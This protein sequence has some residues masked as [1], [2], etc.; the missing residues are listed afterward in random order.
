M[1]V[2]VV[3][4]KASLSLA[5]RY[6]KN[7]GNK[8]SIV[9]TILQQVQGIHYFSNNQLDVNIKRVYLHK[10][11]YDEKSVTA[12]RDANV[13][14]LIQAQKI[15]AVQN[16]IDNLEHW[17][18]DW[19]ILQNYSISELTPGTN[20]VIWRSTKKENRYGEDTNKEKKKY[21]RW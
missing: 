20:I 2:G 19:G 21:G 17:N 3:N 7:R 10:G 8:N 1:T 15:K 5:A 9:R 4:N 13:D 14:F 16:V 11:F 12:L 6:L 18:V